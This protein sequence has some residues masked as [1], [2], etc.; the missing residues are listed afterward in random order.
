MLG[1]DPKSAVCKLRNFVGNA[2]HVSDHIY[3]LI[4]ELVFIC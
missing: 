1:K 3:T 4:T 2:L